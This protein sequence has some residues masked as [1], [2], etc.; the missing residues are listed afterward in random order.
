M[1]TKKYLMVVFAFL[2]VCCLAMLGWFHHTAATNGGPSVSSRTH[3]GDGVTATDKGG[4][5]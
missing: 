3:A 2:V 5:Q 4:K 1:D